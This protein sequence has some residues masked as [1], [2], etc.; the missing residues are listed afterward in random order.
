MSVNLKSKRALSRSAQRER[1]MYRSFR[2]S[3][4]L[5]ACCLLTACAPLTVRA[6][7][8]ELPPI[9]ASATQPCETPPPLQRGTMEE[10]YLQLLDDA[11]LWGKCARGK[12]LLIEIIKYR[13]AIVE[14]FKQ[15]NATK[16]QS[17][18]RWP[19]Q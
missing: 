8:L 4:I 11:A 14:K 3:A 16:P 2:Y 15:D 9:P 7:V 18:W 19:W 5:C 10:L 17:G 13:D 12:D 6:P 1:A